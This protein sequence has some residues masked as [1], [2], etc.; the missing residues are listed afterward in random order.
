MKDL[1]NK[2][3]KTLKKEINEDIKRWKILTCSWVDRINIVKMPILPK[4]SA[5]SMQFLSKSQCHSSQ[6]QKNKF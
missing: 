1:Y 3:C 4:P 5:D 2:N 6:I